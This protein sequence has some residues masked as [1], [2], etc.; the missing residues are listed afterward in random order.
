M[1]AIGLLGIGMA[2]AA[3]LFP[4]A[5]KESQRAANSQLGTLICENAA[6]LAQA[7]LVPRDLTGV[8]AIKA[9][10]YIL[11]DSTATNRR[12][13]IPEGNYRCVY[14]TGAPD[15]GTNRATYGYILLGRELTG[16]KALLVIVAYRKTVPDINDASKDGVVIAEKVAALRLIQSNP[17]DTT[18]PMTTRIIGGGGKLKTGTPVINATTGEYAICVSADGN[19]GELDRVM[20]TQLD[21]G[22]WV[23]NETVSSETSQLSPAIATLS[24]EASL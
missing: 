6:S 4:A 23:V 21:Q 17:S 24:I 3:S 8:A 11:E 22:A 1:I 10:N 18:S 9:L 14:P 16:G 20:S 2:M 19:Q 5:L 13:V 12:I 7:V 15:T